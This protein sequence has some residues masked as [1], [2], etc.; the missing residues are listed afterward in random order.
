MSKTKT[1]INGFD[2][3][4]EGGLTTNSITL[5]TGTPGTGKTI[6]GLEFLYRGALIGEKGLYI[7]FEEPKENIIEQAKQFGFDLAKLEK[8]GK[9]VI[10]YVPSKN[11]TNA[12]LAAI[13]SSIKQDNIKRVV[14]DSVSTLALSIPTIQTKITE[15]TE[16][17]IKRF[18]YNFI[19]DLRLAHAGTILLIGQSRNDKEL[20]SDGVSEFVAD[21]II[22]ITY[23][24]L[25]GEYSRSL[26]I[27]KMRQCKNDEDIHPLEISK[28]GIIV[29]TLK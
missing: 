6:F 2:E 10:D 23:E 19:E 17:T 4:V 26:N 11:I 1:G 13:P 5:L 22:H 3:L 29:H 16:F 24:S 28:K 8:E 14:I 12:V 18:I 15:V 27:R 25:G 9:I 20:S 21:G 7:S